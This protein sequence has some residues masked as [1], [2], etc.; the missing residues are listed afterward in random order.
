MTK[1]HIP[2][3]ERT[4]ISNNEPLLIGD[5]VYCRDLEVR[6]PQSYTF[7]EA[8]EDYWN[9]IKEA[10]HK[11][12]YVKVKFITAFFVWHTYI[13]DSAFEVQHE[14]PLTGLEVIAIIVAMIFIGTAIIIA[15]PIFYKIAGVDP[16]EYMGWGVILL[17]GLGLVVLLFMGMGTKRRKR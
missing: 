7:Q 15:M 14:S 6:S 17:V 10:G 11:P 12:L 4:E 13:V 1:G 5:I 3:G 8:E 9:R 2:G 16:L